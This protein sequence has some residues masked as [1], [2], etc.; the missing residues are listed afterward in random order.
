MQFAAMELDGSPMKTSYFK[1]A[2]GDEWDTTG[3][4]NI[5]G[6]KDDYLFQEQLKVYVEHINEIDTL[7]LHRLE[8]EGG[9]RISSN[10][11]MGKTNVDGRGYSCQMLTAP[12]YACTMYEPKVKKSKTGGKVTRYFSPLTI[13]FFQQ[14]LKDENITGAWFKRSANS[15]AASLRIA[16]FRAGLWQIK[17]ARKDMPLEPNEKLDLSNPAPNGA[18][19]VYR[20]KGKNNTAQVNGDLKKY[21]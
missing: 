11:L 19:F 17:T 21:P 8:L 1:F 9:G 14:Y 18:Y 2:K 16:G 5:G 20:L 12:V 3:K 15:Y 4:K 6:K 10:T 13:A 7:V